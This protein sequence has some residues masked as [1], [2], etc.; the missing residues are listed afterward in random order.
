MKNIRNVHFLGRKKYDELPA[1]YQAIDVFII[2]FMLT[3]HIKYCNPTR[4]YEYLSNGKPVVSA[5]F[6]SAREIPG[7]LIKIART[8]E[9]WIKLIEQSL[10]EDRP[11]L[12]GQRKQLACQNTWEHRVEQMSELIKKYR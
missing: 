10:K 12:I 3:D 1:Y 2:P 9:E 6:S 7:N 8:K 11:E 4:L 5:D